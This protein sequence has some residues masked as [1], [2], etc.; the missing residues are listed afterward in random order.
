MLKTNRMKKIIT[1]LLFVATININAQITLEKFYPTGGLSYDDL[2]LIKLSSSGYKYA[3][4]DNTKITLYNLNHTLFKTIN[5]P[6]LPG[7]LSSSGPPEVFYISEELFNTNPADIEYFIQY[8]DGTNSIFHCGVADELGNFLLYKDSAAVNG[9]KKEGREGFI[10]YTTSG[11]KMMISQ[12]K[13]TTSGA[14]VYSL[15]G[16]LPCQDCS[17]GTTSSRTEINNMQGNSITNYPNP[18]KNETT[19]AYDLPQGVSSADLVFYTITGQEVKRFKVTNAF[20]DILISTADLEAGTYYYQLL[21][22]GANSAGK[23]MIVIK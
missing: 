3:I 15:P 9:V 20:K 12:N 2:R 22:P 11:T 5:F 14:W 1:F 7:G 13:N 16:T 4:S 18:T 23:K 19:V 21:A 8:I 17:N 6:T 10:S